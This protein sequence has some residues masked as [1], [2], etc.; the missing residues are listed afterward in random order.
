MLEKSVYKTLDL[1]L[2]KNL[3]HISGFRLERMTVA[4][5]MGLLF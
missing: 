2:T 5:R 1:L 3:R 4:K